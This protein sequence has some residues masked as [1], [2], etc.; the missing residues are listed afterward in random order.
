MAALRRLSVAQATAVAHFQPLATAAFAS[1]FLA[2]PFEAAA[3]MP[4]L[5]AVAA[6]NAILSAG[7]QSV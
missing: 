3:I 2:T 6:A 5:A 7:K 1:T 4:T